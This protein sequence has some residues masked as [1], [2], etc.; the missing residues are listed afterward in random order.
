MGPWAVHDGKGCPC[1]GMYAEVEISGGRRRQILAG[2]ENAPAWRWTML[3][4]LG[5]PVCWERD[6]EP[7]IRYRMKAVRGATLLHDLVNGVPSCE[8]TASREGECDE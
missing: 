7:V 4:Y 3:R 1:V 5:V 2:K 6:W 8:P